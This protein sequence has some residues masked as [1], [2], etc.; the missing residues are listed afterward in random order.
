MSKPATNAVVALVA[1]VLIVL[2]VRSAASTLHWYA[3][4]H[5]G[6]SAVL[7]SIDHLGAPPSVDD[8]IA[9]RLASPPPTTEDV[10]CDEPGECGTEPD[11]TATWPYP[12]STG[13]DYGKVSCA[14]GGC[15]S[16]G[17]CHGQPPASH[18]TCTDE[19]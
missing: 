7:L 13:P 18:F 3:C 15:D 4:T 12:T 5:S 16:S 8:C 14:E 11:P 2:G 17:P 1:I 6:V 19:P 9:Y 10:L